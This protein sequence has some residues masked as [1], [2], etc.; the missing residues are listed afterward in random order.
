MSG[1]SRQKIAN[2][3]LLPKCNWI[4]GKGCRVAS[5]V[6]VAEAAL[7]IQLLY[8]APV[9]VE[10]VVAAAS[11][12]TNKDAQIRQLQEEIVQKNATIQKLQAQLAAAVAVAPGAP[13]GKTKQAEKIQYPLQFLTQAGRQGALLQL[14]REDKITF[15]N[16]L[17]HS[18][19][20]EFP[21]IYTDYMTF[22]SSHP[23]AEN[24]KQRVIRE[25]AYA[26]FNAA[27]T[28]TA[29]DTHLLTFF[30]SAA[31]WLNILYATHKSV[32]ASPREFA[33]ADLIV[34]FTWYAMIL[35]M[36]PI[37]MALQQMLH[38]SHPYH[39]LHGSLLTFVNKFT[40]A[41]LTNELTNFVD[42]EKRKLAFRFNAIMD[43]NEIRKAV[44]TFKVMPPY[45][46][47]MKLVA[48]LA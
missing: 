35:K 10:G 23:D 25:K 3:D 43:E 44:N 8:G 4:R 26:A 30:S 40:E 15:E 41:F 46:T 9:A 32:F 36:K 16:A 18:L 37:L 2:C 19:M 48:K 33:Y 5:P 6:T 13:A 38:A 28:T 20:T 12:L 42:A 24:K 21:Q 11:P 27:N 22:L 39:V 14:A 31:E 17:S 29:K 7:A 34:L 1:C 47:F 45:E